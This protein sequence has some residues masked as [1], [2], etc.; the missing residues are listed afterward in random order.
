MGPLDLK[1]INAK[2]VYEGEVVE[3]SLGIKDGKIVAI[4]KEPHLPAADETIDARGWLILPGVFDVHAHIHDPNYTHREDFLSGSLAALYGGVTFFMDMPLITYVDTI[5][6][7]KERISLGEKFSYIDFSVHAGFIKDY[8]VNN[9]PDIAKLGIKSFKLFTLGADGADDRTF[10]KALKYSREYDLVVTVH[11][12]DDALT[13][14]SVEEMKKT[15]RVDPRAHH[16]SRHPLGEKLAILKSIVYTEYTK[17]ILHLAHITTEYAVDAVREAK[18]RGLRV[19][20]ETCTHYLVFTY[21][22]ADKW[23]PYLKMNPPL[24]TA[25]DREALWRG[26]AEG[27]IDTVV[28]DHAPGTKEEKEVGWK[29]IWDAWYGLPGLETLLPIVFT[30][31]FKRGILSL[32]RLVEVLSINPAKIFGLSYRK[33][34]IRLGADADLVIIDPNYKRVVKADD[35]HY[36]VGWT[37]YEGLELYGW[38]KIVVLRGRVALSEGEIHIKP[39]YGKFV[40]ATNNLTKHLLNRT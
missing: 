26:L 14:D 19:T 36:K 4:S 9:M 24:R 37:P 15:G 33:G 1:I 21:E 38:P 20:A 8:N 12:E 6:K 30:Y 16:E 25:R 2:I 40:P 27:V 28:T 29:N 11:A 23:G 13:N 10:I 18:S 17:G 3:G 34:S 32:K 35:L 5:D 39:G 22:D 31:G 7:V